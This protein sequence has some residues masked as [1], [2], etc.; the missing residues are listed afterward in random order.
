M[1][2]TLNIILKKNHVHRTNE[3]ITQKVIT[4]T[5]FPA[6]ELRGTQSTN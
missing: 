6:K 2:L 3:Q 5:G 1:T 4:T